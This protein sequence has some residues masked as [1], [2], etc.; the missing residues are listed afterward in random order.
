MSEVRDIYSGRSLKSA[1]KRWHEIEHDLFLL[2]ER[3]KAW[4]RRWHLFIEQGGQLDYTDLD[5][6]NDQ[7]RSLTEEQSHLEMFL[8]E[9][10]YL[11]WTST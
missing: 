7:I 2:D 8:I 1:D 3:K 10:E 5:D 4:Y 6:W 9:N 11:G